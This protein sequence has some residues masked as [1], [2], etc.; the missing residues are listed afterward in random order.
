LSVTDL[1]SVI[2]PAMGSGYDRHAASYDHDT[3]HFNDFRER[4]VAALRLRP[5]DTVL[6]VGCGT[7]L[8]FPW[9]QDHIGPSGKLIAVEPSREM[10]AKAMH[11][12]AQ[13]GWDNVIPVNASA[14]EFDVA[15]SADAVLL[16]ATHD[17]LRSPSA[18]ANVFRHAG[19]GARVAAT[20]GKWAAPWLW[21]LNLLVFQVHAPYVGS[22]DGFD[23]PWSNLQATARTCRSAGSGGTPAFWP[24]GR[25]THRRC[26][27]PP[28]RYPPV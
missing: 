25:P 13:R 1:R 3:G 19:L 5:G 14:T 21:P 9:I 4:A 24:P 28:R 12:A 26:D 11:R 27:Q 6:D 15:V 18:L 7:G 20:G 23:R 16:C 17:V 22:F 2:A 8:C 10:L